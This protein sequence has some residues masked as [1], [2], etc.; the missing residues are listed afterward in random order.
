MSGWTRF[1][2]SATAEYLDNLPLTKNSR[3]YVG[4]HSKGGNRQSGGGSRLA[5]NAG[6]DRPGIQQR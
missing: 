3:L 1:R 4:G 2:H 6:S 5:R